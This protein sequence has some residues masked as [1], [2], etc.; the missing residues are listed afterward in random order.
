MR[1]AYVCAD[2]GIPV[3]GAKGASVH[4]QQIVR[5]LRRRGDEVTVYAVRAGADRVEGAPVVVVPVAG[6]EPADRERGVARAA[7]EIARR[8]AAD[9][10][11]LVYERL[12]LFSDVSARV[13]APSVVEVN[14]PLIDEQRA[15]RTL[16]DEAGAERA[17]RRVLEAASVVACVSDPVARWAADRGAPPLRTVVAPNGV[18]VRAFAPADIG[19]G[20]LETVFVGSLKSWHGV[21][22]AIDAIRGL[23]GV[24]LTIIG[25]GPERDALRRRAEGSGADVRWRGAMP[26]ARVP[27]ALRGMHVGLA[28]YPETADDYF[29]PLKAFEYLAAGL[30]L[31]GSATGQLPTLVE[32]G[33]TGLLVPPGDVGALRSALVR[34]RDDRPLARRLGAAAREQAL[35][36]HDWDRVLDRI[37]AEREGAAR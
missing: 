34:L 3:D 17:A 35:R 24:R 37:L 5:A 28:P 4:V 29:S 16:V 18:D 14:A 25:D 10:C 32:H 2:P 21:E 12:S 9:G 20:P 31:V 13:G 22:T 1:I 8:V 6:G 33:R 36:E 15:H 26:H 19:D 27:S 11:D 7:A 30:A 23:D